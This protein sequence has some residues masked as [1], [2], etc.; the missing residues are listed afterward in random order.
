VW[1]DVW[2]EDYEEIIETDWTIDM[3][4]AHNETASK[5]ARRL[6]DLLQS[7]DTPVTVVDVGTGDVID[8]A[9]VEQ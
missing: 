4:K 1:R 6:R 2:A 5:C 7:G 8:P 3:K 9:E